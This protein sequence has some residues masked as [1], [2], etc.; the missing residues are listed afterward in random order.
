MNASRKPEP[1]RNP[2][3]ILAFLAI[4]CAVASGLSF[5]VRLYGG[6]LLGGMEE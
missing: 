4:L 1:F 5:W 2:K 3:G 6:I